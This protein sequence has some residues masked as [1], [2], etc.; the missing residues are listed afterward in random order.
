MGFTSRSCAYV[1]LDEV[2]PKHA[3]L[4]VHAG[5]STETLAALID[6]G[7]ATNTLVHALFLQ[8]DIDSLIKNC[9]SLVTVNPLQE[10]V[11]ISQT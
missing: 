11:W 3:P 9:L 5:F 1:N 6:M 4:M 2:L 8:M 7:F 10:Y